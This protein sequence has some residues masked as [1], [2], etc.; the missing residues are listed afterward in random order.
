V[1]SKQFLQIQIREQEKQHK[2]A[3][4]EPAVNN[5][6]ASLFIESD[7]ENC[8][9][10]YHDHENETVGDGI[11]NFSASVFGCL[12]EWRVDEINVFD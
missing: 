7:E 12:V 8:H 11:P 10:Y 2:R 6:I 1:C 5:T 9:D 4:D 3:H